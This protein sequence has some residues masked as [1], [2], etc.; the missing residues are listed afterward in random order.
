M[1]NKIIIV[2]Q[3]PDNLIAVAK[4]RG[5]DL[6][7]VEDQEVSPL[8][9]PKPMAITAPPIIARHFEDYKTGQERRRERRAKKR[10][11]F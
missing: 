7:V 4:E 9:T 6:V 10:R 8:A 11:G 2:G 1:E 5:I 3:P